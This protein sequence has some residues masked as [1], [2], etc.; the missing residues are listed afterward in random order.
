MRPVSSLV[1]LVGRSCRPPRRH[2]IAETDGAVLL[3]DETQ[4]FV[5]DARARA[6][7][8]HARVGAGGEQLAL[9]LVVERRADD[10]HAALGR[11]VLGVERPQDAERG[12]GGHEEGGGDGGG[13]GGGERLGGR[14]AAVCPA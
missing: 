11:R 9:D 12:G 14:R 4:R 1:T 3:R 6:R 5:A 8:A 2:S 10:E 13:G 7:L